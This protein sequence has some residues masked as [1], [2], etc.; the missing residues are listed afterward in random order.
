MLSVIIPTYMEE[1]HIEDC[2]RSI[3]NQTFDQDK[4]ESIVV[5]SNSS[6]RTRELAKKYADKVINIKE[7]GV[8]RGRNVGAKIAKGEILLFLDADSIL[9]E[10]FVEKLMKFYNEKDCVCVSGSLRSSGSKTIKNRIYGH[11]HYPFFNLV[12]KFTALINYP[13][14][15][16]ICCSCKKDAFEKI[17][18]F[19]ES[20]SIGE[21][22]KF[23]LAMAKLG[24]C[25]INMSSVAYSSLRRTEKLGIVNGL[26]IFFRNYY[27]M[28]LFNE[29]PWVNDF[30]HIE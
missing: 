18:G 20:V 1:R 25:D 26:L 13:L 21:D 28:I 30:P 16:T 6:D 22:V 19:D 8:G 4:I 27:K 14:F 5:D 11:F 3:K 2:L 15:S 9:H 23:S 7:R 29:K 17:G 10:R 12:M 24:K